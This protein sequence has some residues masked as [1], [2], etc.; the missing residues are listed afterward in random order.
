[1][2]RN[3]SNQGDPNGAGISEAEKIA[4]DRVTELAN[5]GAGHAADAFAQMVGTT[6]WTSVPTLRTGEPF[7][8]P[9][10]CAVST[11]GGVFFQLEGCLDALI[12]ILFSESTMTHLARRLMKVEAGPLD[13]EMA[14]SALKEVGNILASHVASA[15]AD[16]LG[17]RLLPSVP[18]LVMQDV[19]EAF[20]TFVTEAV[21]P[22][23]VRI[24]SE[25]F[26]PAHTICGRLI[27]VPTRF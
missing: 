12:G 21:G 5:I 1:M 23:C 10:A 11:A 13:P 6:L 19:E 20:R 9:G 17:E 7:V 26:D 18:T 8:S 25:L 14:E 15:V 4:L 27:L 16:T 3:P 2:I 22:D 24:E